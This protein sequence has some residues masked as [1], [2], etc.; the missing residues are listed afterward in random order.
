M[1]KLMNIGDAFYDNSH[2]YIC[3]SINVKEDEK[4]KI[5][6]NVEF[7]KRKLLKI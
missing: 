5:T 4:S 3:K 6:L 1:E 7:S 2:Y